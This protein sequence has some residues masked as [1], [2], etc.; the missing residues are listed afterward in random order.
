[1]ARR[2]PAVRANIPC[3]KILDTGN[4]PTTIDV[5]NQAITPQKGLF[6]RFD[7]DGYRIRRTVPSVL[8]VVFADISKRL[9]NER[10]FEFAQALKLADQI[11]IR[12]FDSRKGR[13]ERPLGST[14]F[15]R[16]AIARAL[17]HGRRFVLI[18]TTGRLLRETLNWINRHRPPDCDVMV[19][20]G[21][22]P[23]SVVPMRGL[24]K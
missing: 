10:L 14:D 18:A 20:D 24:L 3:G 12:I 4:L 9:S 13:E 7:R 23:Y 21:G 15:D 11:V 17:T 6:L 2:L 5:G 1:M 19:L 16:P 22:E 8:S